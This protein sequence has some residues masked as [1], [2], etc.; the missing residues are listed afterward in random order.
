[1]SERQVHVLL[2]S[3]G[4]G[5]TWQL[6]THFLR[7]LVRGVPAQRV[8]ASTFTRKAAGEILGR[9]L[10]RLAQAARDR[11]A[12]A[13]LSTELGEGP[14]TQ[15]DFAGLLTRLVRDV[16]SFRVR[17]LDAFFGELARGFAGELGLPP[18][19][20][21]ADEL[22]LKREQSRAIAAAL[23]TGSPQQWLEWLGE[24]QGAEA[25]RT[26]HAA[27]AAAVDKA[28]TLARDSE[29]EA[30]GRIAEPP[31]LSRAEIDDALAQFARTPLAVSKDGGVHKNWS[32]AAS[33]LS[34]AVDAGDWEA[35]AS[36][37]FVAALVERETTYCSKAISPELAGIVD[38]LMR[39]AAGELARSLARRS[40]AART[41]LEAFDA[42]YSKRRAASG[43]L[44]F[45]DVPR[46]LSSAAA[47]ATVSLEEVAERLD[48]RI[49]HVLLDEFQDTAPVQWRLLAP[50][51]EELAAG[52]G[53]RSVFVVGD[54]KQSIYGWRAAEPRLLELLPETLHVAAT[55][56]DLCYRSAPVVLDAVN[57][58]FAG[59][60]RNAS[61][62]R[63][64]HARRTA[65]AFV[66]SFRPHA[67]AH[68]GRAGEV[69]VHTCALAGDAEDGYAAALARAVAIVLE[70]RAAAPAARIAV[71]LRRKKLLA[72]LVYDLRRAGVPASG[73]SGNQLGD[74]GAVLAALSLLWWIDHPE[75]SAAHFHVATSPL[76]VELGV[77]LAQTQEQRRVHS[78]ELAARV[79]RDG[80]AHF[81]ESLRP[82]VAAS[83]SSR[84]ARRFGQL[85][86]AAFAWPQARAARLADFVER[87]RKEPVD[88][89][90][91]ALVKV[92]TVH[93]AKGLEFDAVVL[94]ELE[95]GYL[96]I[97]PAFRW[98]RENGDPRLGVRA[99]LRNVAAPVRDLLAFAGADEVAETYA[100][101][102]ER[103]LRDDF[104]AL[105]VALTRAVHRVDLIVRPEAT[106]EARFSAAGIVRSAFEL[107]AGALAPSSVV[108]VQPGSDAS[109]AA[110]FGVLE[111]GGE[112]P[113]TSMARI[114]FARPSRERSLE[115]ASPS[116][117]SN[118]R[119][120]TTQ[121]LLAAADEDALARGSRWHAWFERIEWLEDFR[122][123]DAALLAHAC[124]LGLGGDRLEHDLAEFRAALER[125]NLR[126]ALARREQAEVWRERRFALIFDAG[127]LD[128]RLV[129]GAFDRV[130]IERAAG[131]PARAEI[132]DFKTGSVAAGELGARL[133]HYRPQLETYRA[134]LARIAAL[135]PAAIT[136]KLF[137][138]ESDVAAEV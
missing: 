122:D 64:V 5:K 128:A 131:R 127:T 78:R 73:E 94:P 55:P 18:D 52:G 97:Q 45:D 93:A 111:R 68:A 70:I 124:A 25:S 136:T 2:A 77:A 99:V 107:G 98:S 100:A 51:V 113:A 27:L 29:S 24:L 23:E 82:A 38:Q 49:D 58:V 17:T 133:E 50:L 56:L 54:V 137:F 16:Q 120:L 53:E 59:L 130:V 46:A 80:L 34:V 85:V 72:R 36:N 125:P 84:D 33:A 117:Q 8:L 83:F 4:T 135:E 15:Q 118:A 101:S 114:E 71:L 91:A 1:M 87:A 6:S 121:A 40:R 116:Q 62:L 7:Q 126:R 10:Q 3:A 42:E 115:R 88:D 90:S 123:D 65:E 11:A 112:L 67:A 132:L 66:A 43:K 12:S 30:W 13:D 14:R 48:A 41:V 69:R 110:G 134:A 9:V 106:K 103:E 92:M 105:Y 32:K 75:D 57:R 39:H 22:E 60:A 81:L 37:G 26:V 61:V 47:S 104:G 96:Q 19:W 108:A 31:L 63:N 20:S 86:D 79:L 102:V 119:Q 35:V 138:V 76:A 74:S 89:S 95:P 44:S 28:W 129:T 109:W 21:V